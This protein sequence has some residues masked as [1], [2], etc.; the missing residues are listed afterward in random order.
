MPADADQKNSAPASAVSP[1][2]TRRFV[3][4]GVIVL[5]VISM[6]AV[7]VAGRPTFTPPH[8]TPAPL[9]QPTVQQTVPPMVTG[10][11]RDTGD[12]TILTI[13]A[14][15]MVL[16]VI[17]AVIAAVVLVVRALLGYWQSRPLRRTGGAETDAEMAAETVL[18]S[19]PD[20]QTVR[21]GI[22][23][24]RAAVDTRPDPGD[25][26]VAAWVGLEETAVDSGV[27][28]GLSETPAEF[29]L[30]ILLH[31]PGIDTPTRRLLRLYENV[32]FGGRAADETARA[33]ASRALAEIEEGW[34]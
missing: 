4:V 17:A 26:I 34:R 22:A 27:G 23:V 6:L 15:I 24:A 8:V 28:R 2:A 14:V 1:E 3:P 10:A 32:R 9:P 12:N 20:A 29:T 21:R 31:R 11:P 7:A 13:I 16:L 19:V 33:E 5:F 25:A 18:E 30:R